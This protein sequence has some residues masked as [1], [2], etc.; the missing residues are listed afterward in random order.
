MD[1]HAT[2]VRCIA[3]FTVLCFV[4]LLVRKVRNGPHIYNFDNYSNLIASYIATSNK[5]AFQN[6]AWT[7]HTLRKL[8]PVYDMTW[9]W[10]R[11]VLVPAMPDSLFA[12]DLW[13]VFV[14]EMTTTDGGGSRYLLKSEV[15]KKNVRSFP[16]KPKVCQEMR[17]AD[18]EMAELLEAGS[19]DSLDE[20]YPCDVTVENCGANLGL[21]KI[22]QDIYTAYGVEDGGCD[23]YIPIMVDVNIYHRVLKVRWLLFTLTMG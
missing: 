8:D 23:D 1:A 7:G 20:V 18:P 3:G 17:D 13:Q 6:C 14:D 5:G 21:A 11:G 9:Q 12:D 15:F 19:R 4:C 22:L 16:P 2:N 10:S